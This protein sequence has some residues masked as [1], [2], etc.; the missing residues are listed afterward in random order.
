MDQKNIDELRGVLIDF[1]GKL[2]AFADKLK[3]QKQATPGVLFSI[4][5]PPPCPK[6][7]KPPKRKRAK[8]VRLVTAKRAVKR[9][10]KQYKRDRQW[11]SHSITAEAY[12]IVFGED[13]I[14]TSSTRGVEIRPRMVEMRTNVGTWLGTYGGRGFSDRPGR[15]KQWDTLRLQLS[16]CNPQKYKTLSTRSW[17]QSCERVT[18]LNTTMLKCWYFIRMP[19]AKRTVREFVKRPD[20]DKFGLKAVKQTRKKQFI[21]TDEITFRSSLYHEY[22]IVHLPGDR[23]WWKMELGARKHGGVEVER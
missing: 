18:G 12:R 8:G 11:L 22:G 21:V 15:Q 20:L 19:N 5:S 23:G 4:D 7:P 3:P 16:D 2:T 9:V 10:P 17:W 6:P 13:G 1:A 14:P